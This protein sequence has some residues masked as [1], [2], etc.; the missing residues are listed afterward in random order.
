MKNIL[1]KCIN[2]V[3]PELQ[4]KLHITIAFLTKTQKACKS[5]QSMFELWVLRHLSAKLLTFELQNVVKRQN[6][7]GLTN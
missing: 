4:E 3:T 6:I 1:H 7:L 5:M 2:V